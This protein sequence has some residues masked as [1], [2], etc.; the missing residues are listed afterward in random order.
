MA[1]LELG[2]DRVPKQTVFNGLQRI[3]NYFNGRTRLAYAA[4]TPKKSV[5]KVF[6]LL[7]VKLVSLI[8]SKS[9]VLD[10]SR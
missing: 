1:C 8:G 10:S 6:L 7:A 5:R 3:K 9:T 4:K 2:L